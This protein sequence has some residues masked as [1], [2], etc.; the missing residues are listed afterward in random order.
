MKNK[1]TILL[2]II[3]SSVINVNSQSGVQPI[4]MRMEP[5]GLS[6]QYLGFKMTPAKDETVHADMITEVVPHDTVLIKVDT[7]YVFPVGYKT[8]LPQALIIPAILIGWGVSVIGNHGLYSSVQMHTDLF[9]FTKGKGGPIDDYLLLSPYAEFGVLLLLKTKC[10]SDLINTTLLIVKSELL[11]LAI[12]EPMKY[13]THEQR[14][15]KS[16]YLSMPSGHTAEA[17]VAAGIV[18]REY[19]HKSAWYGVG[20][21]VLATTVGVFRMVNNKHWEDDV[22]VGAGI[23]MLSTNVV[24]ATHQH[25]F[26]RNGVCLSPS[27]DGKNLG[28]SLSYQF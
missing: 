4:E 21:Y 28:G 13:I 23:G 10:N 1:I 20:A 11:M 22:F 6:N 25:R 15:D 14:P 2:A 18:Y 7:N 8:H 9:N 26:G 24:Y 5:V 3:I 17:F 27:Y 16:D 12:L 19:R